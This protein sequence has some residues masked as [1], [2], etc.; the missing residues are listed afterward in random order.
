[1]GSDLHAYMTSRGIP[2]NPNLAVIGL[3]LSCLG[4]TIVSDA[5]Y[6]HELHRLMP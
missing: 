4:L 1:M 3:I 5:I 6:Q 2:V